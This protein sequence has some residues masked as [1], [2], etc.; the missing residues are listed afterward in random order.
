MRLAS[1]RDGLEVVIGGCGVG[2][3]CFSLWSYLP[4]RHDGGERHLC[5]GVG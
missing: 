5:N 3:M 1:V 2:L 4:K